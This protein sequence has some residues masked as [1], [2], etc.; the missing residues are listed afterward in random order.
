MLLSVAT[1]P[2]MF[3][4]GRRMHS[5]A[6][7][8][9]AAASFAVWVPNI[10][11][12]WSTS[13][14]TVYIP[15]V[16]LGFLMLA[17]AIDEDA[18]PS[19]FALAGAVFS[20]AALTRSM[21]IFF[22]PPAALVHVLASRTPRRAIPQAAACLAGFLVLTLPYSIALSRHFGQVTVIDTHGS[23]HFA[24]AAGTRTPGITDT[25]A[26]LWGTFAASPLGY[27]RECAERARTLLH[28]NGG[29]VLQLYVVAGTRLSAAAWKV[30]V[31]VGSDL[32]L[33]LSCG[34]SMVGAAICRRRRVAVMLLLWTAI[35]VAIAS[36]GGFGGAAATRSN[37]CS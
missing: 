29:R 3:A 21:P 19:S 18:T 2:V 36:L 13:Q 9:I 5:A 15:L 6:A 37:R 25:A 16:L 30:Q 24:D 11:N 17:R 1:I 14:E 23:I 33:I 28:V 20:A 35:N 27:L 7:G 26:A 10:F 32:L 4:L 8:L 22:V 12:V 31:H 34:L